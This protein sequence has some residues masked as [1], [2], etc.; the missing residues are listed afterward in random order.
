[1]IFFVG[2]CEGFLD[3]GV[4]GGLHYKYIWV[5]CKC[6]SMNLKLLTYKASTISMNLLKRMQMFERK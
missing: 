1:M 3:D 2:F 4:G 5:Y 6:R